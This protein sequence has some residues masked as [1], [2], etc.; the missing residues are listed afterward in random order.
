MWENLEREQMKP[1]TQFIC[2]EPIVVRLSPLG[3][4]RYASQ[5]YDAA[6]SVEVGTSFT[7]VPYYLYCH[8]LEL[9]LKAFLL[10]NNVSIEQLKDSRK[11]GHNLT[12]V[13]NKAKGLGLED[14]VKITGVQ[15]GEIRK[16]NDYYNN[17]HKGFEYFEVI[18]AVMGYKNLPD[19]DVLADL[20][21]TLVAQL[22]L[23]CLNAT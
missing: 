8:S 10:T 15:E 1:P 3:F 11:L 5:F 21:S 14:I 4:H 18:P 6:K 20:T 12:K 23:V 2:P 7:P 22:E 9:V 13:L 17:P 19:L 16:A